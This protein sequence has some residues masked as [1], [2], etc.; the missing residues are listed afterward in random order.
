MN[1][2]HQGTEL[3]EWVRESMT[4]PLREVENKAH[5]VAVHHVRFD[6]EIN[7]AADH[8]ERLLEVAR[9]MSYDL[10]AMIYR[11]ECDAMIRK[12]RD[13]RQAQNV[14]EEPSLDD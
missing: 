11:A 7:R 2:N 10:G 5:W 1:S 12:E 4:T 3:S 13:K 8:L 9:R 6:R 14:A